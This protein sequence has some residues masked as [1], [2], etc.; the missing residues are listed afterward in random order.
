MRKFTDPKLVQFFI[1]P[2]AVRAWQ[3]LS[4]EDPHSRGSLATSMQL[5]EGGI[6]VSW[7]FLASISRHR[8]PETPNLL[9]LLSNYCI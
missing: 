1:W 5:A 6:A 4:G 8:L 2:S 7:K 9:V 3:P